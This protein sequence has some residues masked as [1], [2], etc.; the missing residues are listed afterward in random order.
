[1]TQL[2]ISEA[3]DN[4]VIN[5]I[6]KFKISR[7]YDRFD[8]LLLIQTHSGRT[9]RVFVNDIDTTGTL[10]EKINEAFGKEDE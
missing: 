8:R 10:I 4:C 9:V 6:D 3:L 2:S 7:Q 5:D 1:M